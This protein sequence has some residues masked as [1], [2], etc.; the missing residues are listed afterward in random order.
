MTLKIEMIDGINPFEWSGFKCPMCEHQEFTSVGHA[1][2]YCDNCNARFVVRDTAGDPGCVVDC[3]CT[4]EQGGHVYGPCYECDKCDG[5]CGMHARFDGEDL[6][7]PVN[8]NHGNMTR[9]ERCSVPAKVPK[10]KEHFYLILKLCDDCSGWIDGK[11]NHLKHP[12]RKEWNQYLG[13]RN[14]VHA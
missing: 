2:V 11:Y 4:K 6:T 10:H 12:T 8:M 7:C 1:G 13:E 14:A 9:R 5:G 3:F